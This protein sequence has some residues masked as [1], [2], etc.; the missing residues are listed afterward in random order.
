MWIIA[1]LVS[2]IIGLAP[3]AA[4]AADDDTDQTQS[5]LRIDKRLVFEE[6]YNIGEDD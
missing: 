3:L 6:E 4:L 5:E 2:A 1:L